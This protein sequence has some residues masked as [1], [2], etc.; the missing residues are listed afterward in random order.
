MY[1]CYISYGYAIYNIR[2]VLQYIFQIQA[3]LWYGT[4]TSDGLIN[5]MLAHQHLVKVIPIALQAHLEFFQI[6]LVHPV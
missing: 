2:L 1:N 4:K 6:R 3:S 5:R